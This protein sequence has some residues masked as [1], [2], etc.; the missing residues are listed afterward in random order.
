MSRRARSL[1]RGTLNGALGSNVTVTPPTNVQ[2]VRATRVADNLGGCPISNAV[3]NSNAFSNLVNQCNKS[4]TYE[5]IAIAFII[6]FAASL[7]TM[8]GMVFAVQ[9]KYGQSIIAT[10]NTIRTLSANPDFAAAVAATK[11]P[12]TDL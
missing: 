11:S 8:V 6:A 7:V 5:A 2:S 4:T 9:G 1:F 12:K 10:A 3:L